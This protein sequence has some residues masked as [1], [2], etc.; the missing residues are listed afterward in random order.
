MIAPFLGGSAWV[1]LAGVIAAVSVALWLLPPPGAWRPSGAHPRWDLP[2]RVI[3]GTSLVLG[4]TALAPVVGAAL[5][6]YIATFPVYVSV[7]AVFTHHHDGVAGAIE[8][9]R[10]LLAGLYGTAAFMLIVHLAIMPWGIAPA[11]L[12]A[13]AASLAIQVPALRAVRAVTDGAS[14]IE[15][16]PA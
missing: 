5:G 1:L 13:L 2:A 11:F 7:L 9:L 6:G 3:V 16:E 14:A 10:G 15:P 4:F 12:V 8:V